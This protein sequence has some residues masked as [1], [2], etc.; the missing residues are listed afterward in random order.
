MTSFRANLK[1]VWSRLTWPDLVSTAVVAGGLLAGIF[2]FSG[3]FFSFLKYL[4]VLASFYLLF[5]FI[6]WWRNRLLWS[7]RNRLIVAYLFIA[8]V[9][10]LSIVT[11]VVLAARILY[12]QL[13]AYLLYEDIH[14]RIDMLADISEHIAIAHQTLPPSVTESDSE[15]ILAAQSHAV[16]DRELP[17][18]SIGF[19]NEQTLSQKVI[20]A[21]KRAF[22]GLLQE[23]DKLAIVSLRIIPDRKG[24]RVVT[25]RVPV[26]PDFLSTVAPDLGGIQLNLMER[27]TGGVQQGLKYK[28]GDTQ[29]VV[30]RPIV[31]SNRTLQAAM[32]WIDSQVDVVSRLDS[33]YVGPDGRVE[34]VRPVFAASNARPSRLNGRIFT[35]LGELRDS[36]L[37]FFILVGIVFVIVEAAAFATG[38]VLTRRITRAVADL[39]RGTQYVQ[40]MDFSHRVQIERR[41]QLGELGESF[42]RMTGSISQ[43]IEEENKRRRLEDEI[44]IAREVQNQLFPSTLPSVPGVEIEAICKA[45]RSVSGDYY[46]FIQLSPTHIAIAIADISGKG[47]SAAL[48]M[49]SLQAALRSQMLSDGSER[50]SMAELVSRLNKHLVRNTGDD[51]FATFFIAVYDSVTRTLRYTNAGH[52]PAFL[53]CKGA[54]EQLDKGGMV[55]GVVDDYVYEEGSLTVAPDA[56]LIGYSD[57]LIEPENVY[58]EEFGIRRL[59]ESAIHVQG[60]A[61]LMVAES[62]MAAAEEWAG[63]PEQADDMTVIVARLR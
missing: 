45:A 37:I 55:L 1:E 3:G 56:L 52:L 40:A 54:S 28:S 58:G 49:A 27:D 2:E 4:A 30:A 9:P 32:F 29:Y 11:L 41:D 50:L 53:I 43:L 25:L 59:Q 13:G 33:V 44:S 24:E 39:Y 60:A 7:L 16:H 31:A 57:G 14:K 42:N 46:D 62:L 22:A 12:S 38:I 20:P 10:I 6:G 34:L 15:R 51:R 18:L 21:G 19:S 63:T 36:Y 26:T 47:I 8:A 17:G 23:G 61:P 35:S 48:L 5:R